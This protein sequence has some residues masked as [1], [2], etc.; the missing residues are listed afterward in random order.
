MKTFVDTATKVREQGVRGMLL[1]SIDDF[2]T[3]GDGGA[4]RD[5]PG[6]RR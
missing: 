4:Q 1:S 6:R 2:A 5:R 3:L